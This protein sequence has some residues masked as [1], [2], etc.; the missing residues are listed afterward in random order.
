LIFLILA[1][2]LLA[3]LI[4][5]LCIPLEIEVGGSF[6]DK[7]V[8]KARI[9]YFSRMIQWKVGGGS[10]KP[11]V[12]RLASGKSGSGWIG[13]SDVLELARIDGM[14]ERVLG[15]IKKLIEST[16]IQHVETDLRISLGDDYY[17]GML[18]CLLIPIQLYV[19]PLPQYNVVLEPA[20][21][22]DLLLS[23][24]IDAGWQIRPFRVLGPCLAFVCSRPFLHAAGQVMSHRC[25]KK[26]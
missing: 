16:R 20:F 8:L 13:L 18:S 1:A 19:R 21:E 12:G 15:L 26:R 22:E 11:S 14:L 10:E 7:P 9:Y 6:Q 24:K 5:L 2:G 23:G 17:T 4:I 3:L 25:K